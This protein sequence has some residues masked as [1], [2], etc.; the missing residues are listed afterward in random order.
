M[1]KLVFK[2]YWYCRG[3]IAKF[4]ALKWHYAP[5]RWIIICVKL[6][7]KISV[8]VFFVISMFSCI[9]NIVSIKPEHK[10][11]NGK[12]NFDAFCR[13]EIKRVGSIFIFWQF[14]SLLIPDNIK[15]IYLTLV[16]IYLLKYITVTAHL[17]QWKLCIMP[18][19]L[20]GRLQVSE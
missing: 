16:I 10:N 12:I 18:L 20:W 7:V 9:L 14:Y 15:F 17:L 8:T 19:E 6:K 5:L 4:P 1:L 2:S 13:Q 11:E 3:H